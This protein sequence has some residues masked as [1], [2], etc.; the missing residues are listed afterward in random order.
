MRCDL[1]N[2]RVFSS[3]NYI[4]VSI[5][6]DQSRIM[7]IPL[8]ILDDKMLDERNLCSFCFCAGRCTLEQVSSCTM[9]HVKLNFIISW[10]KIS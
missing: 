3:L 9:K 2:Q 5:L 10:N 4:V 7:Q 6:H 8:F 1:A